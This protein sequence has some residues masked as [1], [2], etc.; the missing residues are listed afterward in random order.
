MEAFAFC[1]SAGLN[2]GTMKLA[3]ASVLT[4]DGKTVEEQLKGQTEAIEAEAKALCS[5]LPNLF[6]QQQRFAAAVPEF[7]PYATMTEDDFD[8]CDG[9]DTAP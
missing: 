8:K 2:V 1:A 6:E 7:A 4:G 3:A 9:A 5:L